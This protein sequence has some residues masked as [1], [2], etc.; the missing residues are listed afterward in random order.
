MQEQCTVCNNEMDIFAENY[1]RQFFFLKKIAKNKL[2]ASVKINWFTVY[3][4]QLLFYLRKTKAQIS[5]TVCTT[6]QADQHLCFS[7]PG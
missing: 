4:N 6:T 3:E 5:C 7:L 2:L 1:F